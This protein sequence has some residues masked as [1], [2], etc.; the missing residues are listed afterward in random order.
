LAQRILAAALGVAAAVAVL[1]AFV[2]DS[3]AESTAPA[4]P[5]ATPIWSVRRVPQPIVDAVGSQRLQHLLDAAFPDQASCFLAEGGGSVLAAH[6]PDTPLL[7][8]STQKILTAAA[9]LATFGNDYH[10]E[11]KVLAPAAPADGAVDTL[12][13]VGGGDP[14]LSTAEYRDY[15]KTDPEKTGD[16][17]TSLEALAD[18]IVGAGVKRIPN[19]ILAVDSRYDGV[20]YAASW[21]DGYRSAGE[22]GPIGA[23]TVN[24]GFKSYSTK[25]RVVTDDP[26]VYAASEL[27]RLLVARGVQVGPAARGDAPP[28]DAPEVAKVTSAPLRA[29]VASMVSSSDNVAA[30]MFTKELGA[31]TGQQ[32][33]WDNGTAAIKAKLQELG[34]PVDGLTLADGSGLSTSDRVTCRTLIAGLSLGDR[35]DLASLWDGLPVAGRSGTL[36]DELNDTPLV[37]RMRGKT[38]TLDNVTGLL[39]M[40]DL[41]R[42]V[43]FAFLDNGQ[44]SQTQGYALRDEAAAKVATYPDAPSAD[45]LVPAPTP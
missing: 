11:T 40:V 20:R 33:T 26:G 12:W 28:P 23:L 44:F 14:V 38:G 24:S 37:G 9:M 31:H 45:Q 30:E 8:A 21:K 6:N 16:V 3:G 25:S 4:K 7:G 42:S 35:P 36:V 5:L 1:L 43:R 2:G 15:L 32:G 10:F 34:V 17:T 41:G 19:G 13:M 27:R 22:V 18:A 39:G 29:I